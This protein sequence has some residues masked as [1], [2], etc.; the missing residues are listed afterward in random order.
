MLA[1]RQLEVG[2]KLILETLPVPRPGPGEVLIRMAASPINPSDL[3]LLKGGYL[4]RNFPFTP[5]LEGSGVVVETGGGLMA[6]LRKGKRVAC[7][8]N[9]E[10]DG[11]WAE[12]MKTS[13]MRTVPLPRSSSL[14]QGSMMLVNPMTAMAF[15][16][17]AKEGKHRAMVNNAA[18]SALGKMLIRLSA[19]SGIPLINIVRKEEHEQELKIM[20]ASHVLNSRAASFET[21]LKQ[22]AKKLE[23]TL[24]MDAVSGPQTAALLSAA[25]PKST[26]LT[27]ARLS[28]EKILVDPGD[29]IRDDKRIF[30][31][32]LGNWLQTK[33]ILFKIRFIK[34]VKKQLGTTLSSHINKTFSLNE[35]EEAIMYYREHMSEGKIILKTVYK[36]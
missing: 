2:G 16:H 20:G 23:A 33:G 25:P 27:Y 36:E 22:L 13:V 29:L 10:D 24:I 4:N 26:L 32:R 30:G 15:L 1:V 12:Y 11:T 31:F 6:G 8:P 5:G 34:Q 28:G 35:V 7:T 17:M 14:E 3:A 18:A 19:E 21:D 9:Q